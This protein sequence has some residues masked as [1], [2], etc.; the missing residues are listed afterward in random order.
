VDAGA[1]IGV[2]VSVGVGVSVGVDVGEDVRV[3]VGK[4]V[5]VDVPGVE[6]PKK[7]G[8]GSVSRPFTVMVVACEIA[9]AQPRIHI[10]MTAMARAARS[11]SFFG[12]C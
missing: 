11:I 7:R 12:G 8:T 2:D 4:R 5:G 10:I 6:R 3:G 9:T 1:S